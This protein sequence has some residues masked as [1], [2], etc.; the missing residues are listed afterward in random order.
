MSKTPCSFK[1]ILYAPPPR[2]KVLLN[3]SALQAL[4]EDLTHNVTTIKVDLLLS[5]LK[6][7]HANVMNEAYQFFKSLKG[8]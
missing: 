5:I 6:P 2:K 7:L 3:T 1:V 8:K 4:T